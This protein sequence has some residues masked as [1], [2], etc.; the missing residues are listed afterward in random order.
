MDDYTATNKTHS[1]TEQNPLIQDRTVVALFADADDA[2]SAEQSLNAAGF[3]DVDVTQND[4][5]A[6][7]QP[8]AIHQHGFWAGIKAFF[9]NHDDAHLYGEGVR[10]GQTLLTVHTQQGR[11][12]TAVE[13]LDRFRPTDVE[14]AEQAWRSEGWSGAEAMPAG[15][16][17][18]PTFASTAVPVVQPSP[19]D[20][21]DSDAGN[22]RVRAYV[23]GVPVDRDAQGLDREAPADSGILG[24]TSED[25]LFG[26]DADTIET[27]TPNRAW[28]DHTDGV[29]GKDKTLDSAFRPTREPDGRP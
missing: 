20:G 15:G 8:K 29:A 16:S 4:D 27:D 9:G 28:A 12:A 5:D 17:A 22:V 6:A 14:G 24:D 26:D 21:L 11:A 19:L 2:R 13:I 3:D 18:E 1:I 25:G 23:R 10:R 7:D